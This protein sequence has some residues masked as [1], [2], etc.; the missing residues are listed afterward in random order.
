MR[1]IGQIGAEQIANL[2]G[3]M[4]SLK[5]GELSADELFGKKVNANFENPE[6]KVVSK[7]LPLK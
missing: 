6:A 4:Q 1:S 2:R 3:Y 5:D 7:E